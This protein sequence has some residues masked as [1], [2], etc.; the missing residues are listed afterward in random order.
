[1]TGEA[2]LH[3]VPRPR[4][5]LVET[6][7]TNEGHLSSLVA[8]CYVGTVASLIS[9]ATFMVAL[10]YLKDDRRNVVCREFQGL[11]ETPR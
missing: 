3:C 2:A 4:G 9:I 11:R 1:M 10:I 5:E 8:P 7:Q 6:P